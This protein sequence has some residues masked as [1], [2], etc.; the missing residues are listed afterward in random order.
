[1]K[2]ANKLNARQRLFA[3]RCM[4][5]HTYSTRTDAYLSVYG[6]KPGRSRRTATANACRIYAMPAVQA[7]TE[8]IRA[9]SA[10]MAAEKAEREH[11]AFLDRL[12]KRGVI[13]R[14]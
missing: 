6:D 4:L 9:E 12:F 11:Q 2:T 3:E 8:E 5:F 7:Y 14:R 10:R 1:M 13:R